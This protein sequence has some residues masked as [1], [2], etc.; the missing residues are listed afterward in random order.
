MYVYECLLE[1]REPVGLGLG[2]DAL[3]HRVG[4]GAALL[5]HA[6][7]LARAEETTSTSAACAASSSARTRSLLLV[8]FNIAAYAFFWWLNQPVLPFLS[9]ELGADNTMFG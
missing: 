9:K 6:A 4:D 5:H 8:H 7:Q 3:G 2:D 1:P